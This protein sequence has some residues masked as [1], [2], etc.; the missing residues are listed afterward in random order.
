V[1]EEAGPEPELLGVKVLVVSP[2]GEDPEPGLHPAER[3][4]EEEDLLPVRVDE[5]AAQEDE[6]GIEG[7]H[8]ARQAIEVAGSVEEPGMQ[9]G[10]ER[11]P[12]QAPPTA[13]GPARELHVGVPL[14]ELTSEAATGQD[15]QGAVGEVP[16]DARHQPPHAVEACV[17][18]VGPDLVAGIG[19]GHGVLG[20]GREAGNFLRPGGFVI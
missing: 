5:V 15:A 6:L 18:T 16:S 3:H 4:P 14:L 2:Y 13:P 20:A 7:R 17:P 12:R 19:G 8:P 9:V 1:L 10:E 11:H